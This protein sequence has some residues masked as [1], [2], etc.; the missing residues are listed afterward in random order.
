MQDNISGSLDILHDA[1][2]FMNLHKFAQNLN[3]SLRCYQLVSV[4][5]TFTVSV[6]RLSLFLQFNIF[7]VGKNLR[8]HELLK[9][10]H[11]NLANIFCLQVI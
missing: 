3:S 1:F 11:L 2:L 4:P 7:A 8:F 9:L 10:K 6:F 5:F